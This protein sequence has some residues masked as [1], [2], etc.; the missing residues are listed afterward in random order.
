[1]I[2]VS[3]PLYQ[4]CRNLGIAGDKLTYIP[5]AIDP[6]EYAMVARDTP[7]DGQFAIGVVGRLSVE[8]GVDRA[9]ELLAALRD[10]APQAHLHIIGDGPQRAALFDQALRLDLHNRVHFHGWHDNPRQCYAIFDMLLLPSHTEGLPNVVLEAMALGV[11]VA[12]TDVGGVRDLL[13][14]GQC[15][16][17]LSQ[18]VATWPNAVTPLIVSAERR[19]QFIRLARRRIEQRFSFDKRMGKVLEVYQRLAALPTAKPLRKAA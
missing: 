10:R 19:E 5:N 2:A 14:N 15:G 12:A 16:M 17:I 6:D 18:N 1:V 7:R 4:H 11:P 8:K 13:D 3:P 9:I